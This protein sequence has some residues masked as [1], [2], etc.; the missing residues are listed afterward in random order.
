MQLEPLNLRSAT[1]R[2]VLGLSQ[3]GYVRLELVVQNRPI[4][5]VSHESQLPMSKAYAEYHVYVGDSLEMA[6]DDIVGAAHKFNTL[7]PPSDV[8]V[9][10]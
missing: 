6:T 8:N 2:T 4:R 1:Y 10:S 5:A 7:L 3:N 9:E